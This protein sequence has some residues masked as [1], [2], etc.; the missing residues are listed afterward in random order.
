MKQVTQLGVDKKAAEILQVVKDIDNRL[1]ELQ[2]T[3]VTKA[4]ERDVLITH[5]VA[6]AKRIDAQENTDSKFL[7]AEDIYIKFLEDSKSSGSLTGMAVREMTDQV[8]TMSE[9]LNRYPQQQGG[10]Y[11][12]ITEYYIAKTSRLIPML[13]DVGG[14][15]AS[16]RTFF[17]YDHK[18]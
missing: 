4:S 12:P 2:K 7:A 9:F 3:L 13:H 11:A 5:M 6:E 8:L 1:S 14:L 15:H 18:K 17:G 10:G 16:T